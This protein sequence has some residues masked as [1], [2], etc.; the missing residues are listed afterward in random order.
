MRSFAIVTMKD[1]LQSALERDFTEFV[2]S[3]EG[4]SIIEEEGYVGLAGK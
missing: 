4:Q 2:M 1:R 3:D